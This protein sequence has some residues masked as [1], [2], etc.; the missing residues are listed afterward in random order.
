MNNSYVGKKVILAV[1]DNPQLLTTITSMLENDYRV[2]AATSA[3]AAIK[4][5]RKFT[6]ALFLLD[7]EMPEVNGYELAKIIRDKKEYKKTPI[8]FLTSK[9]SR[10]YVMTAVAYGGNDYLLKP[11]DKAIL[12]SKIQS[13]LI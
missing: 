9:A 10:D 1:D 12:L 11:V 3:N 2:I 5:M 7:I 8:L 4:A 13:N 6:P